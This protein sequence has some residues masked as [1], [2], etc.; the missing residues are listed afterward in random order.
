MKLE[1]GGLAAYLDLIEIEEGFNPRTKK[2]MVPDEELLDSVRARGVENPIH[3][4]R[5]EGSNKL[6]IVDGHRRALAA[7]LAY[8]KG[9]SGPIRVV[10]HGYISDR[11]AKL[12]ALTATSY[13]K[14]LT[15]RELIGVIEWLSKDGMSPVEIGK[16]LGRNKTVIYEYLAV[17]TKASPKLKTAAKKSVKE[18][19]V[20]PRAA[21][22]ASQLPKKEQDKLAKKMGGKSEKEQMEDVRE[23]KERV[24]PKKA[25]S[26][27]TGPSA[28]AKP[29]VRGRLPGDKE[30][31]KYKVAS[32][33]KERCQLL[34]QEVTKR[35]RRAPSNKELLGM[36]KVIACIKG[37]MK[38]EDVFRWD[39]V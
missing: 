39:G 12:L 6:F 10:D 22:Q 17:A 2:N 29:D 14:P 3:V 26:I 9:S 34:E 36:S 8:E 28:G 7:S 24:R 32:D 21:A 31:V 37:R 38:V 4:R 23:A 30:E 27:K 19:G 16:A 1:D 13:G 5:K 18:G 15:K 25:P 20:S 11:E 33:Y 35:L